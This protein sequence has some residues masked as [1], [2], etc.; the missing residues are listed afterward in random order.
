M[1]DYAVSYEKRGIRYEFDTL[2][3]T[4]DGRLRGR[5][6]DL[7]TGQTSGHVVLDVGLGGCQAEGVLAESIRLEPS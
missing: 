3:V 5:A 7:V 4:G 1:S 6:T 2:Q